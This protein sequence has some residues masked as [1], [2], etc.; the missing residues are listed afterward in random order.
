MRVQKALVGL[1]TCVILASA[2][3]PAAGEGDKAAEILAALDG[4]ARDVPG[5]ALTTLVVLAMDGTTTARLASAGHLPPLHVTTT[6]E[7]RVIEGGRRPPL[8][9]PADRP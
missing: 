2:S 9:R 7:L 6:G 5:A 4:F 1:A 3:G 8:L